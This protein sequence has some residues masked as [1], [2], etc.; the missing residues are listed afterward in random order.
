MIF[1]TVVVKSCAW[2][3]FVCLF[4]ANIWLN[5]QIKFGVFKI[6]GHWINLGG[7]CFIWCLVK[8]MKRVSETT[9]CE[10]QTFY[11]MLLP[12]L[13]RLPSIWHILWCVWFLTSIYLSITRR[14]I[15]H[16]YPNNNDSSACS[17]IRIFDNIFKDWNL[18]HFMCLAQFVDKS[19]FTKRYF[20]HHV[21]GAF[22]EN[23]ETSN[24]IWEQLR[25][26]GRQAVIGRWC[27]TI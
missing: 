8:F 21:S 15:S 11:C 5:L 9:V 18:L 24:L 12:V 6:C 22:R 25:F 1:Y 23:S 10:L 19:K 27:Q 26:S 3:Y 20:S 14:L 7:S 2:L 13:I 4:L 16:R 17:K